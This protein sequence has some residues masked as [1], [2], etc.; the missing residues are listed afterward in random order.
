MARDETRRFDW[1]RHNIGHAAKHKVKP[2]EVEEVLSND[3]VF[4]ESEI[5]DISG[6][7]RISELGHTNAGRIL[8]VV[9]T[10]RGKHVRSVTAYDADLKTQALYT[11]A[12]FRRD[13]E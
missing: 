8:F 10:P 4:I 7:E 13:D 3:P 1:D 9:W 12:R 5:D 11:G 6:E 2:E